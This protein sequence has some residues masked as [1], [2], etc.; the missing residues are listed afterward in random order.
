SPPTY[1]GCRGM[2]LPSRRT[3]CPLS[4][5]HGSHRL[6]FPTRRSSDLVVR[7]PSNEATDGKSDGANAPCPCMRPGRA[8]RSL[9][10]GPDERTPR[11]E[12][13]TSELQ[14]R[15]NLVCRHLPEKKN[16]Q[17]PACTERL[18]PTSTR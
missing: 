7:L 17:Q 14:S 2:S 4:Y 18:R 6:S 10:S 9:A 5:P 3:L 12:E 16:H 15:E 13:H 1:L 11:S 8:R